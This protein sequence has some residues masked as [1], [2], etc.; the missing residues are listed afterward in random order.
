MEKLTE[1]HTDTLLTT[2]FKQEHTKRTAKSYD[3]AALLV[4]CYK[5]TFC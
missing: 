2:I 3:F 5:K 1:D 4:P